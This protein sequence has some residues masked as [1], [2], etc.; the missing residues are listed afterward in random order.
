MKFL[1]LLGQ[2]LTASTSH[3]RIWEIVIDGYEDQGVDVLKKSD[4]SMC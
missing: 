4:V 3:C 1:L 2:F